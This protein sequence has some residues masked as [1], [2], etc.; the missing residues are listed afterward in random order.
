MEK[1]S[2][3]FIANRP[4]IWIVGLVVIGLLF[5]PGLATAADDTPSNLEM[6]VK[7]RVTYRI[8]CTS[9]HGATARGD[10]NLAQYMNVPPVNLTQLTATT[11]DGVFPADSLHDIIDGR[12]EGIRGHGAKEMPVWGDV[13]KSLGDNGSDEEKVSLKI[14]E[15]VV[16]LESIQETGAAAE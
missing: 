16:F 9:C 10:G 7:G 15:L 5:T 8:Y 4:L 6:M 1:R 14:S 3:G 2:L 12:K 11:D 13:F